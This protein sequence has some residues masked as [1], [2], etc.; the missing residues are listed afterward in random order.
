VHSHARTVEALRAEGL[1]RVL[2]PAQCLERAQAMGPY[3][4]FVLYPLCGGTPPELAWQSVRLY[5]DEVLAKL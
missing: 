2:T 3:A 4:A 5:A 1:Y